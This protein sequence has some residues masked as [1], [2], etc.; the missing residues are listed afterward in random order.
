MVVISLLFYCMYI[1]TVISDDSL[2]QFAKFLKVMIVKKYHHY[3]FPYSID[4]S[5]HN[6]NPVQFY[7]LVRET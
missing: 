4:I 6:T 5:D 2:G 1:A 3:L 7:L